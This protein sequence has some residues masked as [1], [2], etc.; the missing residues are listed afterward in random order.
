L[1]NVFRVR[2]DVRPKHTQRDARAP[3]GVPF[4]E[5][6]VTLWRRAG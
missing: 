5:R 2:F 6:E 4:E 3:A 1:Q